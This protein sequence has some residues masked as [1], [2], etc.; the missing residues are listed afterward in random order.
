[1]TE[2]RDLTNCN[3]RYEQ[4]F[5]AEQKDRFLDSWGLGAVDLSV[6]R[7]IFGDT[8]FFSA[9]GFDDKNAWDAVEAYDGLLYG[10]YFISN[11]DLP[12]R[13]REGLPLAPYDRTRF[14]GPFGDNAIGYTDYPD[15]QES[16]EGQ[17]RRDNFGNVPAQGLA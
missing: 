6:F 8:P 17:K 16:S 10:R 2:Q 12:K 15:W 14:Y 5:S 4:V 7:D 3:Q 9:G 13:L 11:P 1:M